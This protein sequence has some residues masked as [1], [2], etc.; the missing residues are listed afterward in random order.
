MSLESVIVVGAGFS[1]AV[2][3]REIASA[4]HLV[5]LFEARPHV[6][7]NCH[8][9][10]DP[11]TG[12]MLH[13]YGPHIFHTAQEHV[14]NYVNRFDRFFRYQHR[15]KTTIGDSVYSLPINLLTINQFFDKTLR[16]GEAEK[17]IK[18]LTDNSIKDPCSFE[19]QALS[20]VGRDLYEAFLKGYTEKQ[21]GV[22]ASQLPASI[23]KRLPLRFNYDDN[24]FHHSFQGVP[25]NGYTK[26]VLGILDHP[27]IRVKLNKKFIPNQHDG[28]HVFWT[29]PLD[30]YFNF[31]FGSL[32]YRTLDFEHFRCNGDYL[33][34]PVMNFGSIDVPYTRITE[35]K[36]FAPWE[37]H[38]LTICTREYSR[39]A[40]A[41]DIPYYPVR[42][43]EDKYL[44]K[45]YIEKA[46]V[47][48]RV[49]FMGRL[50]TYRYLD[51]D[52]CISEALQVAS[53]WLKYRE[54]PAFVYP[55]L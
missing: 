16:P 43:V 30:A 11:E 47:T 45:R 33:G 36:H 22:Q 55:P 40:R 12:V 52:I 1:G 3:A 46:N 51:M 13:V 20:M 5:E 23:L 34:T 38:E 15:V 41:N 53:R 4:G 7:G 28:R 44:L 31:E 9:E 19:E 50:G 29:G 35:H 32:G 27:N 25:E 48:K 14:W 6:A 37:Q 18:S 54:L 42:L 21:W 8:T 17:F 26:V 10:R 24:Y 39:E 49:T 2:L